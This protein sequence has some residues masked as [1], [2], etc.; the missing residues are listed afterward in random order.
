MTS[1]EG[2]SPVAELTA[3]YLRHVMSSVVMGPGWYASAEL[4]DWYATVCAEDGR[5]PVSVTMFG[6]SL[7]ALGRESSTRRIGVGQKR[8][9][10]WFIPRHLIRVN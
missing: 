6:R 10:C 2:A 9:R 1:P 5:S 8:A 7:T 3:D 4:Y